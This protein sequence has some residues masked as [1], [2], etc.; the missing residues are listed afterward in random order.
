M[1]RALRR[2]YEAFKDG[3]K[4]KNECVSG[5][6]QIDRFDYHLRYEDGRC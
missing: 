1:T 5:A 3:L 6:L 2:V 4:L